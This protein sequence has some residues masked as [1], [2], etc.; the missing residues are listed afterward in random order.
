M[1]TKTFRKAVA[2]MA[3]GAAAIGAWA[4]GDWTPM[5]N[6]S[7][8]SCG[9]QTGTWHFV[10]NQTGSAPAG[11]LFA[12]FSTGENCLVSAD[13]T[14]KSVQ[15]FY[16]EAGGTLLDARSSVQGG[17]LVLSDFSCR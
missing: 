13:K 17:R 7:G 16:C 15:H 5:S 6:L 4:Y 12:Q 14:L 11:Q 1:Q 2:A 8:Q 10:H 9:A 3:L